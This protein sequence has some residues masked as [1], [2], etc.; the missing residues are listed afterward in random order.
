MA[1]PALASLVA[2]VLLAHAA[3]AAGPP[4]TAE[5]SRE[6]LRTHKLERR[7]VNFWWL[8][9]EYWTSAARE[10]GRSEEDAAAMRKLLE[11]YVVIGV[12]DASFD[13]EGKPVLI[14]HSAL[15][16][17][18]EV[19]RNGEK[20]E[21][22]RQL[23]PEVAQ[24]MPELSYL[25]VA[26]LGP[27]GTGLRLM[28]FPNLTDSGKPIATGAARAEVTLAYRWSDAEPPLEFAWHAPL[29]AVAGP[30]RCS[31]GGELLEAS[32]AYCPWHGVPTGK[33]LPVSP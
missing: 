4:A 26:S 18:I 27:L 10:L 33:P 29:T 31:K 23:N 14:E 19:R 1:R 21:L 20:V 2:C 24:Q 6:T 12:L 22:L 30:A 32:W 9:V 8:P 28:F 16:P 7:V 17:R 13:A 25:M 3:A 11:G 15:A 5:I